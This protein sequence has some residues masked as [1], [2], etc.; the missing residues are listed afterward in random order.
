MK[1]SANP[2][3]VAPVANNAPEF[4]GSTATRLVAEN[5]PAGEDIGDPVAA[6]DSDNGD[7][8]TYSLGGTDADSFGFVTTSGQLQTKDPLDYEDKQPYTVTVSV[9][10]GRDA[11]GAANTAVDATITVTV[12][13]EN[14]EEP[15]TVTL[16]SAQPLTGTAFVASLTDPDGSVTSL[17]WQWASSATS[18]GTFDDITGATSA[19]YTPGAGDLGKYLQA[20]ATY[21]DGHDSNKSAVAVSAKPTNSVPVFSE[22]TATRSV[23]EDASI[24]ANVGT[25]VTATD[26]DTLAYTLAGTDAASFRIVETSG[27]LQTETLL[28]YEVRRSYEVTVTV[29][30][31]WGATATITVTIAVTNVEE[32]GSVT[33]STVQPQVGT[34]VTAELTDPDG[35]PTRVVWQWA[36]ATSQSGNWTN[37]SSGVDR[38]SYTPVAADVGYYLRAWA[39]YEDPQGGS[40]SA[41]VVSDNPVQAAP[42]GNNSAPVFSERTAARSVS[43]NTATETS[44]GTPVTASDVNSDTL[45][46]TLG[47]ADA[48]SFVIVAA[49]GQLRTKDPLDYESRSSY[50]VTVTAADP[51]NASDSIAVTIT[52][53][54]EDEAGAVELSTVQPQ[55]GT[56]LTATL[57]RPRR[58]SFRRRLA[59]GGKHYGFRPLYQRQQR[60]GSG[61]LHAGSRRLGPLPPGHGDIYRPARLGQE[62]A[63]SFVQPRAGSA[64]GQQHTGVFRGNRHAFGEGERRNWRQR[65]HPDNRC[66]RR[67]RPV[68]LLPGRWGGPL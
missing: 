34:E 45:T 3:Q 11:N 49:S 32:P 65:R 17:T 54:N 18:G 25:P 23:A 43:E 8:L 4:S 42:A 12:N 26:A 52:V 22:A 14:V 58:R 66:R 48:D 7:T 21:T 55:V 61:R 30:D 60:G 31:T 5:T 67:K 29:T 59:V 39:T 62:R 64:G 46:Y 37:I 38:G 19:T 68:N 27:Q 47:G 53:T 50:Q 40:K 13:L 63:C 44:F 36:R 15:G 28:D 2:V 51:S 20:T 56:A 1:I 9:H 57:D 6:T 24:S 41:N 35:D 16:S 10:D 33:L